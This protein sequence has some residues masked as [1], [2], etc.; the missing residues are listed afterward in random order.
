MP[1][2]A[3][4]NKW[5]WHGATADL[6]GRAATTM[7]AAI[8]QLEEQNTQKIK[9]QTVAGGKERKRTAALSNEQSWWFEEGRGPKH[10]VDGQTHALLRAST[11]SKGYLL[12]T[13]RQRNGTEGKGTQLSKGPYFFFLFGSTLVNGFG[14][15]CARNPAISGRTAFALAKGRTTGCTL[16][17]AATAHRPPCWRR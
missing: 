16:V 17:L 7:T 5:R 1:L 3:A 9:E 4:S 8:R 15:L 12:H 10:N 11:Q 13:K 14:L 2:S 6:G